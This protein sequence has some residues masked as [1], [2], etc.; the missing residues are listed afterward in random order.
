MPPPR[1]TAHGLRAKELVNEFPN[2]ATKVLARML[3]TEFPSE[4]SDA[5]YA[6]K[7]IAYYRGTNGLADRKKQNAEKPQKPPERSKPMKIPEPFSQWQEPWQAYELK[8]RRVLVL[9]DIHMPYHDKRALELAIEEGKK[10]K[11][12]AILIN[13]DLLDMYQA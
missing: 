10:H 11:V 8:A 4:Y 6:A 5:F 7:R 12:D 9:S 2:T 3:M 13:G 1:T